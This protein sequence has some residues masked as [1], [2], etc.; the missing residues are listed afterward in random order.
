MSESF[1]N[2]DDLSGAAFSLAQL[3]GAYRLN[4]SQL[5][6]GLV[7]MADG[8]SFSSLR[9]LNGILKG[10]FWSFLWRQDPVIFSCFVILLVQYPRAARD[11]LFIGKHAFNKGLYDQAVQWISTAVQ[12]ARTEN[13]PQ[14]AK[15]NEIQPFLSTAIRVVIPLFLL[16]AYLLIYSQLKN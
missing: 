16:I 1:P 8:I 4:V 11:C 3:Q 5:A 13:H 12:V 6:L 10:P 2:E 9:G 15:V 14:S 7:Q